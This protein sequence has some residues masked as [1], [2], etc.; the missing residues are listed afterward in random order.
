MKL[1]ELR[2]AKGATRPRKRVGRG[3]GSGSGGTAGKGHKGHKA[4]SGGGS[5]TW[6][7]GGQMPLHRQIPKGGFK[8]INRVEYQ[9]VNVGDLNKLDPGTEVTPALLKELNLAKKLRQKVK[10]LGNGNLDR[11]LKVRVHAASETA[12]Q[13]VEAAGGSIE[14][15]KPIPEAK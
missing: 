2:P 15:L 8:N 9:A 14:L 1:N 3:E 12:R 7:E 10:L 11:P 4:R 13:K 5:H 6:F